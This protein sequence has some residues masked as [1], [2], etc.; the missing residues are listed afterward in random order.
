MQQ[1]G[2]WI[3]GTLALGACTYEGDKDL[4]TDTGLGAL[5]LTYTMHLERFDP[6]LGAFEV[7]TPPATPRA[8][9]YTVAFGDRLY[10]M[11]GTDEEGWALDSVESYDPAT[12]SW[13]EHAPLPD[14]LLASPFVLG[15]LICLIGAVEASSE[16]SP[17]FCYEPATDLWSERAPLPVPLADPRPAALAGQALLLGGTVA[18]SG[19]DAEGAVDAVNGSWSYDPATDAWSERAPLPWSLGLHGLATLDDRAWLVG[20]VSDDGADGDTTTPEQMLAYDATTDAWSTAPQMPGSRSM[21]GVA[22]LGDLIVVFFGLTSEDQALLDRYDP[23]TGEWSSA[24][25][26]EEDPNSGV[27]TYLTAGDRLYLLTLADSASEESVGSSGVLWAYDAS[28]DAWSIVGRRDA[29]EGDALFSGVAIGEQLYFLG[30]E[31]LLSSAAAGRRQP[32]GHVLLA[33]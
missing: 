8:L 33:R 28:D 6:A 25:D 14:P 20:G 18:E 19:D 2:R 10:A 3:V 5:E 22:A 15:D 26:P 9:Y 29:D 32:P 21:F 23:S 17:L 30:T 13:S 11:G 12:D 1:H 27:Y 7:L 4:F 16:A 31:Y 24:P